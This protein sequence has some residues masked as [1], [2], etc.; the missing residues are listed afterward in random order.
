MGCIDTSTTQSA[1]DTMTRG[2]TSG[3]LVIGACVVVLV[4]VA[5]WVAA[6]VVKDTE[7]PVVETV[8]VT[9]TPEPTVEPSPSV[10]PTPAPVVRQWKPAPKPAAKKDDDSDHDE[11]D[12]SDSVKDEARKFNHDPDDYKPDDDC[13]SDCQFEIADYGDD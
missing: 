9:A 1:G 13:D 10:K 5:G 12:D 2:R 7:R 3:V 8:T 6:T 11:D 4:F